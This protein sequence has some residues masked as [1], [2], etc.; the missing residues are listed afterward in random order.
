LFFFLRTNCL[1]NLV[2]RKKKPVPKYIENYRKIDKSLESIGRQTI[3]KEGKALLL[4]VL[5]WKRC[6]EVRQKRSEQF[7]VSEM[8][9]RDL[10][11]VRQRRKR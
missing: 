9:L 8:G 4:L 6:W 10:P 1:L 5:K 2:I 3:S 11:V 7:C